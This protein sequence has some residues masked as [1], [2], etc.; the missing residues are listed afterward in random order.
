MAICK[1]ATRFDKDSYYETTV[2]ESNEDVMVRG[3][4][5]GE[6]VEYSLGRGGA[7]TVFT[8]I[9][10]DDST[11]KGTLDKTFGEIKQAISDGNQVIC[12]LNVEGTEMFLCVITLVSPG[13]G[14]VIFV[15]GTG[16]SVYTFSAEADSAY[17]SGTVV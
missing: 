5:N 10:L 15:M 13:N 9:T 11:G 14:G 12:K 3:T 2:D 1:S 4:K 7:S 8:N 16:G 6:P 17:P